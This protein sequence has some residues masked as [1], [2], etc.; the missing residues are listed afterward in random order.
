MSVILRK[1]KNTD[2][3]T[4]LLLDIYHN[5]ERKYEFLKELKLAKASG[6]KDRQNNKENL[7][8]AEKIALKR[9][10][11][12]SASDYDMVT[13]IGKNTVISEWMQA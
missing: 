1:R 2:G 5:G 10:H 9:A 12:L 3:T 13:D 8:L 6:L 4:T 11:E 7:E